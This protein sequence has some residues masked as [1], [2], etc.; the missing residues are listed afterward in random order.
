M[1]YHFRRGLNE[2]DKEFF[3]KR[4]DIFRYRYS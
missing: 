3:V 2:T 1:G 4:N